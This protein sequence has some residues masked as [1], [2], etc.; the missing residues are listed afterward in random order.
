MRMS[1]S[2]RRQMLMNL[3]KARAVRFGNRPK[4]MRRVTPR[5]MVR[6]RPMRRSRPVRRV[7]RRM[8]PERR[9][10]LIAQLRKARMVRARML[11]RRR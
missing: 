6:S 1:A 4:V 11:R 8:T 3:A 9:R 10:Q 7:Q 5:R 2:R